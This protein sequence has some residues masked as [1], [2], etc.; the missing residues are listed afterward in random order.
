MRDATEYQIYIG[1]DYER[2]ERV[3]IQGFDLRTG[4]LYGVRAYLGDEGWKA[5]I[6]G[7]EGVTEETYNTDEKFEAVMEP[8]LEK[9]VGAALEALLRGKDQPAPEWS[10]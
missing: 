8:L 10:M 4:R 6:Q 3:P 7:P 9:F 5:R 2:R 1:F